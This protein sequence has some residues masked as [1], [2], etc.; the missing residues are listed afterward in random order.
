MGHLALNEGQ[1]LASSLVYAEQPGRTSEADGLQV[2][3]EVVDEGGMR[4]CGA[5][6]GVAH[7]DDAGGLAAPA[8]GV[9]PL[10]A[11]PPM[12]TPATGSGVDLRAHETPHHLVTVL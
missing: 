11:M 8:N 5:A 12:L 6:D 3:Q 10:A 9:S 1:D 2:S 4:P 7:A